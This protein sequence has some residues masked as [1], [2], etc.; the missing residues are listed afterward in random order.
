MLVCN[1]AF[2]WR[3]LQF[4]GLVSDNFRPVKSTGASLPC[5]AYCLLPL[6]LVRMR[7]SPSKLWQAPSSFRP[8][9][10]RDCVLTRIFQKWARRSQTR[11]TV[12]GEVEPP[13]VKR[14]ARPSC[15]AS[16]SSKLIS[17]MLARVLQNG[18]MHIKWKR[19]A[20]VME[21][22]RHKYSPLVQTPRSMRTI[23]GRE[24]S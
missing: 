7:S 21:W 24:L 2:G 4:L 19:K 16:T 20:F 12:P 1:I 14:S 3:V 8:T 23:K 11:A 17:S 13:A 22:N 15:L 5:G 18:N 9:I 6:Y 10:I